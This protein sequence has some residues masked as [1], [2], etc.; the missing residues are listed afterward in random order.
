MSHETS[1]SSRSLLHSFL[2]ILLF[3][4]S[5]LH[6]LALHFWQGPS[7]LQELKFVFTSFHILSYIFSALHRF[8]SL[9]PVFA[10]HDPNIVGSQLKLLHFDPTLLC[11]SKRDLPHLPSLC[12]ESSRNHFGSSHVPSFMCLLLLPHVIHRHLFAVTHSVR[13][14]FVSFVVHEGP[15]LVWLG[16]TFFTTLPLFHQTV[17]ATYTL[18]R[19]I[20]FFLSC[21]TMLVLTCA[22]TPPSIVAPSLASSSALSLPSAM[23]LSKRDICCIS[24]L[25]RCALTRSTSTSA[26]S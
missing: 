5:I 2:V 12:S 19:G 7:F 26:P 4:P 25:V 22:I 1:N 24:F 3:G 11:P 14:F 10:A 16:L 18:Q 20:N 15:L 21:W 8:I 9:G 13:C 17:E 23:N 6:P